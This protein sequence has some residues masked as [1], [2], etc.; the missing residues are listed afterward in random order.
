MQIR[1]LG[2]G[3]S[4]GW[5]NPWCSCASCLAAHEQGVVRA[6]TSVLVD[7]RLLLELGPAST[8]AA[9]RQ[10]VS[11]AGVTVALVTHRHVD[12]HFPQ[13]WVWRAWASG[14]GPL[15]VLAPPLVL[16][17]ASFDP[18]VTAVAAVPGAQHELDGYV[19]RVLEANHPD[20]AVLYDDLVAQPLEFVSTLA[21]SSSFMPHTVWVV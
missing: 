3:A 10:G 15:Q 13:A 16:A 2:S 9:V 6:Q 20:D 11:L 18:Q 7:G 5:P 1:L 8:Q 17:D 21:A 4:D 12:H 14:T 19:V